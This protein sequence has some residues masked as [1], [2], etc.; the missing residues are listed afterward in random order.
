MNK[1]FLR[2]RV[3]AA[4]LAL[5]LAASAVLAV[6]A[7]GPAA[8]QSSLTVRP[9]PQPQDRGVPPTF[10]EYPLWDRI[11]GPG[12]AIFPGYVSPIDDHRD[13][14]T[15]LLT[16]GG[17]GRMVF[18]AGTADSRC[19]TSQAPTLTVLSAPP[20]V[21]LAQDYGNFTVR[22][23]DAGSTFCLGRVVQGTRLFLAG[24]TPR[25]GAQIGGGQV[26]V[27]VSYPQ[28]GR[29]GRSYTHTVA[30]PASR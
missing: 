1:A 19:Q 5:S 25:G 15:S 10:Q 13:T 26:T 18:A 14:R 12:G 11:F 16:G 22:R 21:R 6:A 2:S 8:A 24:K 23:I 7:A 27:R 30:L 28:V 4:A 9:A 3:G 29:S 20:G 17:E